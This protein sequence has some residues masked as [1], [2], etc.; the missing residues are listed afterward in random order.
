[1][2]FYTQLQPST[3]D[4]LGKVED[5]F[6]DWWNAMRVFV[7]EG[8]DAV[9]AAYNYSQDSPPPPTPLPSM[10]APQVRTGNAV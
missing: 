7:F 10:K 8:K 2:P 4:N 6:V 9:V 5:Q 3:P 1:M